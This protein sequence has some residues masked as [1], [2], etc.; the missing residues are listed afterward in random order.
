[1]KDKLKQQRSRRDFLRDASLAA[2]GFFIVPRHVLG[3]GFIAPSDRLAIAAIGAGGKGGDD[4]R[5]F[6]GS[7]EVDVVALCDVDDR[8]AAGSIQKF[9]KAKYYKGFRERL[10]R[11]HK[12]ID[13]VSVPTPDNIHPE[14]ALSAT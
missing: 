5:N 4:L 6:Y 11:E 13:A 2:T 8:Q 3:K 14:A 10:E 7:G 9:P 1:M 12:N